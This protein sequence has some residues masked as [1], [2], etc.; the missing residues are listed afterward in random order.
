MVWLWCETWTRTWLRQKGDIREHGALRSRWNKC[1]GTFDAA[2]MKRD[3][4]LDGG[5]VPED[6]HV[7][8]LKWKEN[9]RVCTKMDMGCR[10]VDYLVNSHIIYYLLFIIYYYLEMQL[11]LLTTDILLVVRGENHRFEQRDVEKSLSGAPSY[12]VL[13]MMMMSDGD[14]KRLSWNRQSGTFWHYPLTS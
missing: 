2:L 1:W 14:V 13:M 3:F 9:N 5:G 12:S 10:S 8:Q 4:P 11:V 6:V 7:L